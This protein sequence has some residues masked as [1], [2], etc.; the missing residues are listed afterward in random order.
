MPALHSASTLATALMMFAVPLAGQT[1]PLSSFDGVMA[2][3][4]HTMQTPHVYY[5][6]R[7][8]RLFRV[9]ETFRLGSAGAVRPILVLEANTDC[10]YPFGCGRDVA[11]GIGPNGSCLQRFVT[12]IGIAAAIGVAAAWRSRFLGEFTVGGARGAR[13]VR[14]LDANVSARLFPHV[15][16]VVGA[17]QMIW[18]DDHGDRNW[19]FPL[20][21]ALRLY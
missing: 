14:Y 19:F 2:G 18:T 15:A 20:S 17:R 1:V 6:E 13:H 11:C 4:A 16:A 10:V 5:A 7:S 9:A 12:P 3:G 8:S 21:V